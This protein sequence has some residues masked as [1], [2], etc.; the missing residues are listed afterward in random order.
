MPKTK[1]ELNTLKTEFESLTT[2]LKELTEDELEQVTG[3]GNPLPVQAATIISPMIATMIGADGKPISS[4]KTITPAVDEDIMKMAVLND[5][6][7]NNPS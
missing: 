3:G 1:E 7:R 6:S 5:A 2:K 4:G